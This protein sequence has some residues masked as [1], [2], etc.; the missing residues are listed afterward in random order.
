[1][2]KHSIDGLGLGRGSRDVV[3]AD[4]SGFPSDDVL[5]V[6]DI[7]VVLKEGDRQAVPSFR[8]DEVVGIKHTGNGL[9][10]RRSPTGDH[11]SGIGS[12]TAT[13]ANMSGSSRSAPTR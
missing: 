6:G 5:D 1:M 8:I 10:P 4:L 12:H 7:D 3:P 2:S 11:A 9:W 13:R